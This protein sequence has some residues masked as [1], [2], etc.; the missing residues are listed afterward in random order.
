MRL[1]KLGLAAVN[2]TVGAFGKNVAGGG[3]RFGLDARLEICA[4]EALFC[5]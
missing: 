5:R 2:T 4:I 3:A 1:V